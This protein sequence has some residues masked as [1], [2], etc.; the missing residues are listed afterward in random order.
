MMPL[1][2]RDLTWLLLWSTLDVRWA[3]IPGDNEPWPRWPAFGLDY[4]LDLERGSEPEVQRALLRDYIKLENEF[5]LQR[6]FCVPS[7]NLV[8][9][10]TES[11]QTWSGADKNLHWQGELHQALRA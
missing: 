7:A 11:S 2:D 6:L 5:V 10:N 1:Y 4:W 9:A 8:L 3:V